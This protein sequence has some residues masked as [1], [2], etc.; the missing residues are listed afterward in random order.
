[1]AWA[2]SLKGKELLKGL[3]ELESNK[4]WAPGEADAGAQEPRGIP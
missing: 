1:M 3:E 4:R 2:M